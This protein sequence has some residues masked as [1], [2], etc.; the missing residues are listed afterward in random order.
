MGARQQHGHELPCRD[1]LGHAHGKEIP[2][3]RQLGITEGQPLGCARTAGGAHRDHACHLVTRDTEQR[4]AGT[5]VV[6][7]GERQLRQLG[8]SAQRTQARCG[9]APDPHQ[10]LPVQGAVLRHM[11]Q[12]GIEQLQLTCPYR[13]GQLFGMRRAA[14]RRQPGIQPQRERAGVFQG[15]PDGRGQERRLLPRTPY[16]CRG[17][18]VRCRHD[19]PPR[20]PDAAD[21]ASG[22]P[23]T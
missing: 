20:K 16:R 4:L 12:I 2:R 21:R 6:G 11:A 22:L 7:R 17:R 5:Q 1:H 19:H 15:L 23:W 13:G 8:K 10:A 18:L 14:L 3:A 9:P